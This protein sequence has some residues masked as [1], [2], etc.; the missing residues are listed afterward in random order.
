M[1]LGFLTA[2][3]RSLFSK[4]FHREEEEERE[5]KAMAVKKG[6]TKGLQLLGLKSTI[7]GPEAQPT[8][9]AN[10]L[11]VHLVPWLR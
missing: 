9:S 4:Y 6:C 2:N 5:S 1:Q 10:L 7:N 8:L 11:T 3:S